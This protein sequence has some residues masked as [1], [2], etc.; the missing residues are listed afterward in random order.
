M[1][2]GVTPSILKACPKVFGLISLSFLFISLERPEIE[3]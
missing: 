3:L 1:E 2:A